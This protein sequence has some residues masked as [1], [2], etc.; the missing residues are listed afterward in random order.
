MVRL[1]VL[2]ALLLL[3]GCSTQMV[4]EADLQ[5]PV[6]G[7]EHPAVISLMQDA[8]Q[9]GSEQQWNRALSYLDQARRIEP[10]NPY[11]LMRQAE[12]Y[13]QLGESETARSL[14]QRARIYAGDDAQAEVMI[15]AVESGLSRSPVLTP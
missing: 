12:A 8:E 2:T 14:L 9:A 11:V 4:N 1:V 5:T 15:R 6:Y 10:R 7:S 3:A 13:G